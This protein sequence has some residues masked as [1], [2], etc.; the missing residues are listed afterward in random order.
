M[1]TNQQAIR[2]LRRVRNDRA[3]NLSQLLGIFPDQSARD[4]SRGSITADHIREIEANSGGD[5]A[6]PTQ[7]SD[8]GRFSRP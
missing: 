5:L 3:G 4:R 2:G 1:A 8:G 6:F 7:R